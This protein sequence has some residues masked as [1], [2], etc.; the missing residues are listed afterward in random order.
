MVVAS[1]LYAVCLYR[2]YGAL[3]T[4]S[5]YIYHELLVVV[6]KSVY[7]GQEHSQ[8]K[9]MTYMYIHAY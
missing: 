3:D 7:K 6:M 4:L 2:A 9:L 1:L 8:H 5:P